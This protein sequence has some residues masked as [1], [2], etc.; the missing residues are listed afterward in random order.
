MSAVYYSAQKARYRITLE[1][2]VQGDFNPHNI[3]WDKTLDIQGN[4]SVSAY[5]EDLST[6]DRW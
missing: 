3:D 2:D 6:P 5:I 1:L 4:E